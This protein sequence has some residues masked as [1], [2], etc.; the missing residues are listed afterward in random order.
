MSEAPFRSTVRPGET[1]IVDVDGAPVA[2]ARGR[3]LLA[4]LLLTGRAGAAAD[5]FCAIGQC[6]RCAVTIDGTPQLACMS[7][8]RGGEIIATAPFDGRPLPWDE[9]TK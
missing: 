6:Q 2:A 1:I 7:V 9:G 4:I 8:P 5:F 3:S